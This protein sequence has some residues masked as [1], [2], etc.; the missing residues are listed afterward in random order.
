MS[1][2]IPANPDKEL[3]SVAVFVQNVQ[4]HK[5]YQ[6]QTVSLSDIS[7]SSQHETVSSISLYPNPATSVVRLVSPKLIEQITIVDAS[8]RV[9]KVARANSTQV[10]VD[11]NTLKTRM[12]MVRVKHQGGV[13][14]LRFIKKQKILR[15]RHSMKGKS[16][17]YYVDFFY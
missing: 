1:W 3:L 2:Q 10:D 15:S 7:T 5:V 14:A 8:G 17:A 12:Y 6:V 9:L 4:T 11:V 13:E 16:I